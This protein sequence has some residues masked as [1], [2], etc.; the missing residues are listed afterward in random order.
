MHIASQVFACSNNRISVFEEMRMVSLLQKANTC[1][2]MCINYEQAFAMGT[3][4]GGELLEL[5]IGEI[6]EGCKADFV[7]VDLNDFSMMPLGKDLEQMLPNL[8]YSMEPTAVKMVVTDGKIT[9]RDG[10]LTGVAD[11]VVR[12]KVRET[13]KMLEA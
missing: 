8:V 13:M 3:K 10:S 12:E 11:E 5:P 2:A 9:V 7:G 6:R 1:D 4:W